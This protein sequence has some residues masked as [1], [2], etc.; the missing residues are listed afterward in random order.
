MVVYTEE[1]AVPI[2]RVVAEKCSYSYYTKY[3]E[4]MLQ[5]VAN[6]VPNNTASYLRRL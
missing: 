1:H 4:N 6:I 3:V 5:N 2:V